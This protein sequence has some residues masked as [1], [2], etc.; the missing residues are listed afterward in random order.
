MVL[1]GTIFARR[2][3]P[4]QSD[5]TIPSALPVLNHKQGITNQTSEDAIAMLQEDLKERLSATIASIRESNLS[6][7]AQES[8]ITNAKNNMAIMLDRMTAIINLK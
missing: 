8:A 1:K 2:I 5:K 6:P 4:L 3:S 7:L